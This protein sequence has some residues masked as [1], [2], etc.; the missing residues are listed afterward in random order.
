MF[1]NA[2][3]HAVENFNFIYKRWFKD[4]ERELVVHGH[5]RAV[6]NGIDVE[7]SVCFG[8]VL[9]V[10]PSHKEALKPRTLGELRP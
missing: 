1:L 8:R 7:C 3:C 6:K 2:I 9:W 5:K 10:S 4:G